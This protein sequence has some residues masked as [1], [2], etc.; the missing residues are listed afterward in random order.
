MPQRTAVRRPDSI[1]E[2]I[3]QRLRTLKP[4]FA[5]TSSAIALT[6]PMTVMSRGRISALLRK[7]SCS[8]PGVVTRL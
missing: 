8:N 2:V 3:A 5:A 6:C 1:I 7:R 4:A